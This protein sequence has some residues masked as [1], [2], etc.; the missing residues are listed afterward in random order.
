MQRW[1]SKLRALFTGRD[2]LASDLREELDA[3][4]HLEVQDCLARGMSLEDARRAAALRFGNATLIHE[5]AHDAWRF[6]L[7]ETILH[8]LAYAARILRKSPAFTLAALLTLALGIGG[9]TLMFSVIHAVLLTPLP[10]HDSSR[11]VRLSEDHPRDNVRDAGFTQERFDAIRSSSRSFADLAAYFIAFEN[12][13]LSGSAGPIVL[14]G[15]RVSHNFLDI[16][17]VA[18]ALGRSFLPEEDRRGGAP[19]AMISSELWSSR[20]NSD[21][22]VIGKTVALNSIPHTIIGV[23]PIGF[24]FPGADLDVWVTR[25]AEFSAI[26]PQGWSTTPILLGLGRLTPGATLEQAQAELDVLTRQFDASHPREAD[27]IIRGALFSTHLVARVR[28]MLWILFGA[29]TLVLLGA[30]ANVAGLLLARANARSA[31]FTV[32]SA[33][34]AARS[35]LIGQLLSESLLLSLVAAAAGVLL[36]WW[37]AG[38]I[39]H[40]HSIAAFDRT[41]D[42]YGG[43]PRAS[44]I[45]VDGLV[46]AFAAAVS[47][48]TGILFGLFPALQAS[49]SNAVTILH[50]GGEGRGTAA[51]AASGWSTRGFL[52]TFQVALSIMLLIGAT[53]LLRTLLHLYSEGPG[54]QPDHLLTM[55]IALPPARYGNAQKLTTFYDELVRRA[56]SVSGVRSASVSLTVPTGAKWAAPLQ[57]A[58]EAPLPLERRVQS[59]YQSV[60]PSYFETLKIPV[61]RGRLFTERDEAPTAPPVLIINESLARRFWPSYPGGLDPV[62]QH[63]RLGADQ[64]S[65][66]LEVVGI[67]ADVR[68]SGL[69]AHTNPEFFFPIHIFPPQRAALIVRTGAAPEHFAGALRAQVLAIDPDQP[70]S[71]VQTMDAVLSGSVGEQRLAFLLL[72]AFAGVAVLLAIVGLWGVISYSVAQRTREVGIRRALGAQQGDILRLIVGQGLGLTLAGVVIGI[73]AALALTRVM[74]GLLFGVTATDPATFVLV[75]GLFLVVAS[76]ASYLP[77]LRATRMDPM[78]ALR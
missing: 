26:P 68:E 61:R 63:I 3:H 60:S 70:V 69:A 77:A 48:G 41:A 4:F 29:V 73:A 27:V 13:T 64:S 17:G 36:A 22:R 54:F 9:N 28:T 71:A 53:L 23:L 47:I 75:A 31:E 43:L 33:L 55:Q 78:S 38:A 52:V 21:P 32:R 66:G 19:V 49:R 44:E 35:R 5:K 76:F 15:A 6:P 16:V 65:P 1:W 67:V 8:D 72:G 59:Q 42:A 56:S 11:L 45:R 12:I 46:L 57:P 18:P 37:G 24:A 2:A 40:L 14:R 20:F 30:C 51:K 7:F 34:G 50:A 39:A 58:A 62:A 25:P 74:K 10:Y